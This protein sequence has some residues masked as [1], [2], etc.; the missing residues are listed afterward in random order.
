[1]EFELTR[2]CA[3]CCPKQDMSRVFPEPAWP[4]RIVTFPAHPCRKLSNVSLGAVN[5]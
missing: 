2:P 5:T 3:H 1:M 4:R